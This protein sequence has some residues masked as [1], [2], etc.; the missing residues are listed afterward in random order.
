MQSR[1]RSAALALITMASGC[2]IP[3]VGAEI[4]LRFLPVSESPETTPVD[5]A[6]PV[7]RF[8]PNR[9]YVTSIGAR[10]ERPTR[11]RTNNAGWMSERDYDSTLTTPLMAV[12]GDSY[13]EAL[14]VP[15]SSAMQARLADAAG[16]AHRVYAFAMS[17][18]PLS[19]Y[20]RVGEYV[21]GAYKPTALVIVVVG[22]DFDESLLRYRVSRWGLNFFAEHA[23]DSLV[24]T[25]ADDLPKPWYWFVRRSALFRYLRYNVHLNASPRALIDLVRRSPSQDDQYV[26]NVVRSASPE[27][28]AL[29]QRAVDQFLRELPERSQLPRDKI[30]LVVDG[31]R[32]ELYDSAALARNANSYFGRMREYFIS[33]GRES[34]Y[35]VVDLQPIFSSHYRAHGQ[36]FE[37]RNEAH[38][39]VVGHAV[40]AN[41]VMR[42]RVFTTFSNSGPVTTATPTP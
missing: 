1:A 39:N 15:P 16:P 12:I 38:W 17:G 21:R 26:G 32:P 8:V 25:R 9:S 40:A 4:G 31:M 28:I 36:R 19:Q 41:A 27:R 3:L 22:N 6:N 13:V 42:T 33:R 2:A 20:L 11:H 7:I 37:S 10:L 35:D 29:S 23:G 34:G 14:V 18:W 24:L 30:V 5:S